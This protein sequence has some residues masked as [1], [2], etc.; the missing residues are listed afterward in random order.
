MTPRS[1]LL[2]R[3]A[4]ALVLFAGLQSA[5]ALEPI[6][7]ATLIAK[8]ASATPISDHLRDVVQGATLDAQAVAAWLE[9]IEAAAQVPLEAVRATSGAELVLQIPRGPALEQLADALASREAVESVRIL[10]DSSATPFANRDRLVLA[11]TAGAARTGRGQALAESL[12][13]EMPYVAHAS[14]NA[15]GGLELTIDWQSTTQRVADRLQR[16]DD[17]A[18]IQVERMLKPSEE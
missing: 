14:S 9:P 15:D 13:A 6:I 7:A 2:A 18:Y 10:P 3:A 5:C 4:S 16:R 11:L 17:I 12:L 8:P 1:S